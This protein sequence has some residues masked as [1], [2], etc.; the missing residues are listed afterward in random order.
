M[1]YISGS[2]FIGSFPFCFQTDLLNVFRF[3]FNVKPC[4]LYDGTTTGKISV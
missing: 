3:D 1:L 4:T 2:R